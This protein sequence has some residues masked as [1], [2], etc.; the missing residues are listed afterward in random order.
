MN[1]INP[2]NSKFSSTSAL[3]LAFAFL[4]ALTWALSLRLV[5]LK[6]GDYY[7][8]QRKFDQAVN[9]YEKVVRKEG[10][11]TKQGG[12]NQ[13]KYENDVS[14]LQSVLCQKIEKKLLL[15]SHY[16]GF[17]ESR[18]LKSLFADPKL[19]LKDINQLRGSE[20]KPKLNIAKEELVGLLD[21]FNHYDSLWGKRYDQRELKYIASVTYFYKGIIEE[22][23][24]NFLSAYST[25]EEAVTSYPIFSS[26]SNDRRNKILLNAA[27]ECFS[28]P[29]LN[30]IRAR[31]LYETQTRIGVITPETCLKLGYL[32]AKFNNFNVS[33]EYFKKAY[34][35]LENMDLRKT[36]EY[37]K[38]KKTFVYPD[39]LILLLP[40]LTKRFP[41]LK[42]ISL[43]EAN[44]LLTISGIDVKAKS[45]GYIGRT[46]LKSPVDIIIRSAGS[47][48]GNRG[49]IL[50]NGKNVSQNKRGYNI[51]VLNPG[52][53]ELEKSE[54]FDTC[55]SK[56]DVQKMVDFIDNINNGK[57]VCVAAAD[58]ASSSLSNKEGEV[59]KKI[60]GIENLHGK[61]RWG[62]GIIGFK[63]AKYGEAIEAI[64]EK[65]LEIYVINREN[66]KE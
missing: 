40:K 9:W 17:G 43:S 44:D 46:G 53:G 5:R 37:L 12:I 59:F 50:I 6:L 18:D 3:T 20:S 8:N 21:A 7:S 63:G 52:T 64:S 55:G 24:N 33:Y 36:I 65:P 22:A 41:F 10:L 13:V 51:V 45:D 38:N 29:P 31:D 58:D 26:S 49:Q 4:L 57:I 54:G 32:H 1:A 11:R 60:G 28:R 30:W 35:S 16:L 39:D 47:Y 61:L 27:D 23:E 42:E 48:V 66:H 56:E 62:H 25:Y 15:V 14:K 34:Y 19:F 2:K